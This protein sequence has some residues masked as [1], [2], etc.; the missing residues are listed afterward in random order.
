MKTILLT[1]GGTGGHVIPHLSLI[2]HLQKH[3]DRIYYIGSHSGIEKEIMKNERVEYFAISA[4]KLRRDAKLSSLLI[5]FKLIKSINLAKRILKKTKPNV[6]FSKGGFVSV[7]VCIAA[8]LLKIPI[9]SHESDLTMGLANKVIYKLCSIFCT[10]FPNTKKLKKAIYTGS[11][12]R[13]SLFTGNKTEALKIANITKEL[14]TILVMGGSTGALNLNKALYEILPHLTKKF[15]IIHIVGKNK[16]DKTKVF[17]NYTQIEY[18]QNIQDLFCIS[19]F[20]VSR[21]GSNAI[22]EFLALQK[23]MLLIPLPKNASRGDQIDNANYFESLGLCKT[24]L[25]ENL[26]P[27]TF[28][29]NINY[30]I[31]HKNE[32]ISNMKNSQ[33]LLNGAQ[34]ILKEIL[35][36]ANKKDAK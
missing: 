35:T 26:T 36:L 2:P 21:A 19:D 25:E 20:I 6:V 28:E 18:C 15:N 8:K 5:P 10:S 3:F 33:L 11:P 22:F 30:I 23:P 29:E 16:G 1:G 14:P 7:P 24:L 13:Q 12:I 31:S 34:N 32:Y 9:I 17:K 27:K 4:P